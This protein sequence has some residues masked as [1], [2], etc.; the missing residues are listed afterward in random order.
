MSEIENPDLASE[1]PP[2][3]ESGETPDPEDNVI[4][5]D[6][7]GWESPYAKEARER[8]E[9]REGEQGEPLIIPTQT[10]PLCNRDG[11]DGQIPVANDPLTKTCDDCKGFGQTYT[12]SFVDDYIYRTCPTCNGRGF[13][14]TVPVPPIVVPSLPEVE[15][16]TA[17]AEG[18]QPSWMRRYGNG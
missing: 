15:P 17:D 9:A 7:E 6:D 8:A 12:G 5:A 4:A 2:H 11:W 16:R 14:E 1:V 3:E 18:E 10:C 13:V